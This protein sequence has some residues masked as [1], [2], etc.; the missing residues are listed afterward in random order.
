MKKIGIAVLAAITALSGITPAN[1]VPAVAIERVQ[2]SDVVQ[3]QD[4]RDY[5]RPPAWNNGGYRPRYRPGYR[6]GWNGGYRYGRYNGYRG[7]RYERYGY[8][9]HNDGWW[10]PLAAFGTG[11]IIGG[12][13]AAPPRRYETGVSARHADWCYARYRS[14]RAWDNSFQP[15]GGPRQQCYSPYY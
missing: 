12:A 14:Y 6:P 4:W 9:R 1:A 8:R 10:Y 2:K 5:R 13:I 11:V 7:Y 15:Y 3:V